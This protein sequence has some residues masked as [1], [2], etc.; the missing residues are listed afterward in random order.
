[1]IATFTPSQVKLAIIVIA[2]FFT[3]ILALKIAIVGL[4][5]EDVPVE[6]PVV[7]IEMENSLE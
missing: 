5:T 1:M 4:A 7:Q 2:V 6:N 3:L